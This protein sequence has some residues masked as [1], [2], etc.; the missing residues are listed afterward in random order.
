MP[1]LTER[2]RQVHDL[3]VAGHSS[4]EIAY[5]LGLSPRTIEI[6]RGHILRKMGARNAIEWYARRSFATKK[7]RPHSRACHRMLGVLRPQRE[8]ISLALG[9]APAPFSRCY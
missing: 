3:V 7:A 2:E 6:H 5:E 8:G 9:G 4:K 1:A